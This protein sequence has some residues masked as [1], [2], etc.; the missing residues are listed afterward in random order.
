MAWRASLRGPWDIQSIFN[1]HMLVITC[2]HLLR[3]GFIF[4]KDVQ[5][6]KGESSSSRVFLFVSG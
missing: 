5:L 6:A 4:G 2:Q 1:L 3:S